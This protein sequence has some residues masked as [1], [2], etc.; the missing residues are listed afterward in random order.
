MKLRNLF[1]TLVALSSMVPACFGATVLE[2]ART[3]EGHDFF[4]ASSS[5]SPDG[6]RVVTASYDRTAKI[7]NT[8]TGECIRTLE[9]HTT[10]VM[11]AAFS[12]DGARIL[13]VSE[14]GTAKIWN[15]STGRYIHSLEW[16]D[17]LIVLASFSPD[18][19]RI[20]TA[21]W[22]GAIRIW[23]IAT[24]E[25]IRALAGNARSVLSVSFSPD[26]KRIVATSSY[27]TAK[28]W[29]NPYEGRLTFEQ[30]LLLLMV[31]EGR[32][33][34][35]DKVEKLRPVYDSLPESLKVRVDGVNPAWGKSRGY[36]D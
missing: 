15:A 16:S 34:P 33:I 5:F 9:G 10:F 11:S 12:P 28:I 14:D 27:N 13:T 17:G 24:G 25:C 8:E 32:E 18:G 7:W 29:T 3:L 21:S 6:T 19:T 36:L 26:G 2:P 1:I 23:D 31:L 20:V 4:V 35:H 30:G 22:G